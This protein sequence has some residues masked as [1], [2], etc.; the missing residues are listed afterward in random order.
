MPYVSIDLM[1]VVYNLAFNEGLII[2]FVN[3]RVVS[4]ATAAYASDF[5]LVM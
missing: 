2:S 5:R 1:N 3:P 4:L